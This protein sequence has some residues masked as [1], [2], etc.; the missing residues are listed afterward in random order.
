VQGA[1]QMSITNK[2]AS[3]EFVVNE[4]AD[5]LLAYERHPQ[6]ISKSV[7][8]AVLSL[9]LSNIREREPAEIQRTLGRLVLSFLNSRSSKGLNL[10]R[11]LDDEKKLDEQ[12]FGTLQVMADSQA[13]AAIYDLAV[14]LIGRGMSGNCWADIEQG[15]ALLNQAVSVGFPAAIT[16]HA[17][18]WELVRPRLIQK[19]K[20]S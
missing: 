16:Y 15:E 14:S 3:I 8:E 5:L 20:P 13:P 19:F 9:P 1:M 17:E 7:G 6:E 10:P 4:A 18:V 11:D 2:T 12:H